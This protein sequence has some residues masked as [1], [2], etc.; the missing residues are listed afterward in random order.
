MPGILRILLIAAIL[1]LVGREAAIRMQSDSDARLK[2][3]PTD[4]GPLRAATHDALLAP[5][6]PV[7]YLNGTSIGD[8]YIFQEE[9]G[10]GSEDSASVYVDTSTNELVVLKTWVSTL[11]NLRS[12]IPSGLEV[13]FNDYTNKWPSEIE[14]NLLLQSWNLNS[15]AYVPVKDYF[16]L[17]SGDGEWVWAMISPYLEDGNLYTLANTPEI[18]QHSSQKLDRAFRP[19]FNSLLQRL[20]NLHRAGYCHDDIRPDNV[21]VENST[22]WVLGGLGSVRQIDHPWHTSTLWRREKQKRDCRKNDVHGMLKTYVSFLRQA[23]AS[24]AA[25]GSSFFAEAQAWGRLYWDYMRAPVSATILVGMSEDLRSGFGGSIKG[26][27][28]ILADS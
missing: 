2:N 9:F 13:S 12:F 24:D 5:P 7:R 25:F 4:L 6:L 1:V 19:A 11:A 27:Q 17:D 22:H 20:S 16:V 21:L 3:L 26:Q 18:Q 14:A 10:G 28:R 8:R 15:T 23:A